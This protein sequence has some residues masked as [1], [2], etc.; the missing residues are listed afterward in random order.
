MSL[1]T[2]P[3]I[4]PTVRKALDVACEGVPGPVFVELPIDLLYAEEMVR[5]MF[6]KEVGAGGSKNLGSRAL[7]LYLR[8]HLYRQFNQPH[9]SIAHPP[10][11]RSFRNPGTEAHT[12]KRSRPFSRVPS[13]PRW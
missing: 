4:G 9:A 1:K 13:G 12:R 6:M 3:S 8:G 2:V 11:S 7:E 10:E 5:E